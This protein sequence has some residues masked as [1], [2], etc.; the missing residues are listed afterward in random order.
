MMRYLMLL[1][2][3]QPATP[4]PPELMQAIA[5]LG[6]E[7][8]KAGAL[9]DFAGLAPSAAG[10]R[11]ELTSGDLIVSDGPFAEAR[12]VVSYAVYDV[13]SKEEAVE[14]GTRF[15]DAHRRHWPEWEGST[16]IHKLFGPEDMPPS[17]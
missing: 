15:L 11:L 17:A 3:A 8:T 5:R 10:A 6:E 9:L 13:R 1:K 16:D 4:P 2:A 7:A 12:E 14:W